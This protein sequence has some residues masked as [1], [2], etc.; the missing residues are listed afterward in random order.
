MRAAAD[1]GA[2]EERLDLLQTQR[3]GSILEDLG[4]ARGRHRLELEHAGG[5]DQAADVSLV[6]DT[7]ELDRDAVLALGHDDGLSHAGEV[8]AVLDDGARLLEDLRGDFLLVGRHH[9]VLAAKAADEVESELDLDAAVVV[10][11]EAGYGHDRHHEGDD[12]QEQDKDRNDALHRSR[13]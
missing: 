8:D 1:L 6:L 5:A 13:R 9:L 7:G 10:L 4:G 3:L 12:E 11:P 2:V